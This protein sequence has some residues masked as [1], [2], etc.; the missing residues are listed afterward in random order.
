[1]LNG[2]YYDVTNR[3]EQ[4]LFVYRQKLR[5]AGTGEVFVE[6]TLRMGTQGYP[7]TM[8]KLGLIFPSFP[9]P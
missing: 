5:N 3:I 6:R 4:D 8:K 7:I 9:Y 2:F 1:M